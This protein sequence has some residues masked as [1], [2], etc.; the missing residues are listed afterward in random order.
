MRRREEGVVIQLYCQSDPG[1]LRTQIRRY[2][3]GGGCQGRLQKRE[4]E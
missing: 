2:D 3:Q 4:K 1:R